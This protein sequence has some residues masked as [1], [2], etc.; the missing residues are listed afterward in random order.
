MSCQMIYN[1][2]DMIL[3]ML[4]F[5]VSTVSW[6]GQ[7]QGYFPNISTRMKLW[8]ETLWRLVLQSVFSVGGQLKAERV[9]VSANEDHMKK[10]VELLFELCP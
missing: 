10:T 1:N 3:R 8:N 4:L 2:P 9:G 6:K 7:T 5:R